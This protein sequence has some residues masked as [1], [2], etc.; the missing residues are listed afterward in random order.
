MLAGLVP[1]VLVPWTVHSANEVTPCRDWAWVALVSAQV[2][3]TRSGSRG[4][5][6]RAGHHPER[7]PALAARRIS[8]IKHCQVAQTSKHI[9]HRRWWRF[10]MCIYFI[11]PKHDAVKIFFCL[12]IGIWHIYFTYTSL[13]YACCIFLFFRELFFGNIS[14]RLTNSEYST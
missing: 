8:P 14:V 9:H 12:D 5:R 7:D 10:P 11:F 13:E 1:W 3:G 4:H 6:H 2:A